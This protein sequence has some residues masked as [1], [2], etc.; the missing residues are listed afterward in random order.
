MFTHLTPVTRTRRLAAWATGLVASVTLIHTAIFAPIDYTPIVPLADNDGRITVTPISHPDPKREEAWNEALAAAVAIWNDASDHVFITVDENSPNT[1][2]FTDLPT[3]SQ[4]MYI[5]TLDCLV[6][7]ECTFDIYLDSVPFNYHPVVVTR[8][9]EYLL[10]H[11]L[12]HALGL[13]DRYRETHDS[14]MNKSLRYKSNEPTPLDIQRV[15]ARLVT[16]ASLSGQ[17]LR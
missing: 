4:A 11:E 8:R 16:F 13:N 9:G 17:P 5:P 14:L 10:A 2:E 15:E 12:G 3:P 1:I 7:T 6:G